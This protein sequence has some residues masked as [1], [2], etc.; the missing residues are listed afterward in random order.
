MI[1]WNFMKTKQKISP[2]SILYGFHVHAYQEERTPLGHH[3]EEG[4]HRRRERD[5]LVLNVKDRHRHLESQREEG[6]RFSIEETSV[7]DPNPYIFGT[8]G[9]GSVG[10]RYGSRS[11][12]H[13]A[14]IV[15][16]TMIP[17]I[18]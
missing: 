2:N 1:S 14:I 9:Y 11:F 8:P 6:V 16:K 17:T 4:F 3:A 5:N 15:G 10:Q 13:Q 12:Y 18:M 7:A